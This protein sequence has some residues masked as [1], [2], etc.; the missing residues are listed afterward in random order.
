MSIS[1]ELHLA[2]ITVLTFTKFVA[3]AFNFELTKDYI[4]QFLPVKYFSLETRRYN[5]GF[6]K[7]SMTLERWIPVQIPSPGKQR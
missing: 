5:P 1:Y 3:S 6:N 2:L 7:S 4:V